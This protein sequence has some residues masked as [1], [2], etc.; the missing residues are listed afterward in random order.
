[1]SGLRGSSVVAATGGVLLIASVSYHLLEIRQLGQLSGPIAA[2]ALDG[3]MAAVIALAGLWLRRTAFTESEEWPVA[4]Y[5]V[6]GGLAGVGIEVLV[7]LVHIIEGR[8]ADEP[9]FHLL[10][11]ADSGALMLFAAGYYAASRETVI[12]QYES[13]LDNSFQLT[14]L[15]HPDGTVIEIN[16][17][18]LEF[19]GLDRE[20]AVGQ[21][22]DTGP[23]WNH[24]ETTQE[25]IGDALD[26]AR[27]GEFVREEL[28]VK[29][30]N[31]AS[32]VDFSAKP[33]VNEQ[34]ETVRVVV[35]GRDITDK[36]QQRQHLQVLHRVLRHNIR[37]D[38]M[39]IRGWTSRAAEAVTP[40]ERDSH[41]SRVRNA[42]DSWEKLTSDMRH[43]RHAVN[44]EEIRSHTTAAE[45]LITDVVDTQRAAHPEAEI[46]LTMPGTAAAEVPSAVENALHEAIENAVDASTDETPAVSVTVSSAD[47]NWVEVEVADNGP[48]MPDAEAAVLETGDEQ[49]LVHGEGSGVWM[50]RMLVTEVGGET[51]VSVSDEGTTLTIRLPQ[52]VQSQGLK[53][54]GQSA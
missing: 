32:T 23:V 12:S 37:N 46:D 15:L 28:D 52:T 40:E 16:D 34:D 24:T 4:V 9:L 6:L 39:K 29:G 43:I 11:A 31:G 26:R 8:P 44:S 13:L 5:T 14:G 47:R 2:L 3:G 10:I 48:G 42:L 17:T 25:R 22:F 20:R 30:A 50:I 41:L 36:K 35:E 45:P 53:Q 27:D 7:L 33:V 1:M 18:A 21:R 19:Y 38:I 51:A 49:P 54:A